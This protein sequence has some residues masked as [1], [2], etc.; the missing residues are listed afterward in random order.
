[1][2]IVHG[3]T[4]VALLLKT[5]LVVTPFNLEVYYFGTQRHHPKF[6]LNSVWSSIFGFQFWLELLKKLYSTD[7]YGGLCH[8]GAK[9][10]LA[11][12][13]RCK[14]SSNIGLFILTYYLQSSQR[15]I[16]RL[17]P[18]WPS[19]PAIDSF[20]LR[21]TDLDMYQSLAQDPTGHF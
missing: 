5:E 17:V 16:R 20:F 14:Q 6:S 19:T 3:V 11:F 13:I 18:P 8:R 9:T 15:D 12:C 10:I 4:R 21:K 7:K 2:L 1:M